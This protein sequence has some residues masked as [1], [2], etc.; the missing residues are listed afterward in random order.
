[1]KL[2]FALFFIVILSFQNSFAKSCQENRMG[3]DIG[4]GSTK[5]MVAEVDICKKAILKVLAQDSR[6]VMYNEDFEKSKDGT[7]G[8]ETEA[9]G[10]KALEELIAQAKT[11]K[12]KQSIGVA[13]SVFRKAKNG[14]EIIARFAKKLK[15][16]LKVVSQ[17]EEGVLGYKSAIATLKEID[18]KVHIIVWD[19]GGGSMQ[20]V[21]KDSEGKDQ[22]YLGNLASVSFKNL[23]IEVFQLK[24]IEATP[25][26]NP[27]G[28]SRTNAIAL[29][30]A[31]A[32]LHVPPFFFNSNRDNVY[33]GIGGVHNFSVKT[34]LQLKDGSYTF[35]QLEDKAIQ[36]AQKSDADLSGDYRATD[37]SNLLLV[38]GFME[39][40]G[41]REVLLAK[42]SLLEGIVLQ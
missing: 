27:I 33:L 16:N 30:K 31:Y 19:I 41:I 24:S 34:Q 10:L 12:V 35:R 39:A 6:P 1:V 4:S 25:S 9:K 23:I 40:L 3:L 13:T 18:P 20:M 22:F 2:T 26:P 42:A 29:A 11:F 37:V 32:R 28:L 14:K 17:E 21:G 38:Q 15:I 8:N 36:Q 5:M 7:I